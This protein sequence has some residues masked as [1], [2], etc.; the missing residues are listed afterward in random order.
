MD[1]IEDLID[2]A[3][4]RW[5]RTETLLPEGAGV[6]LV[7]GGYPWEPLTPRER[8]EI[9]AAELNRWLALHDEGE[10]DE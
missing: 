3:A 1:F 9:L 8:I 5:R 6:T 2:V 7:F 10:I 4:L